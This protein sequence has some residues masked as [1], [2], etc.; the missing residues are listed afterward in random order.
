MQGKGYVKFFLI[1]LIIVSVAQYLFLLPTRKV[2]SAAESFATKAGMTATVDQK[3]AVMKVARAKYL[4]SMSSEKILSLPLMPSYTYDELKRQQLALGLDLKGGMSVLL[5]VDLAEF[6]KSLSGNSTDVNFTKALAAAQLQQNNSQ[7]DFVSLFVDEY[8]KTSNNAPLAPLFMRNQAFGSNVN[9]STSDATIKQLIRNKANET[10]DLTYKRLKE[11]IDKLGVVQPNISLDK[12]RDII[13]V[14]LPGIDNP[15]RARAFLSA[16]AKLEFWEVY[17]NSDPG[18]LSA[19]NEADARLK[20]MGTGAKFDSLTTIKDTSKTLAKKDSSKIGRGPLL[21]LMNLMPANESPIVAS[22]EKNKIEQINKYLATPEI[23]GLF[24]NDMEFRWS[25]KPFVD[26]AGK[27]SNTYQLYSL[28]KTRGKNGPALEGDR[29]TSAGVNPDPS[30]SQIMVSLGMDNEGTRTWGQL[31]TKCAAD[32]NREIAIVLDDEVE[33]SPRVTNPILTGNSQI[34]GTFTLQEGKDLANILQVGK[35]P[36]KTQIIQ[37]SL[38]GPSLGKENINASLMSLFAAFLAIV[39]FMIFYYSTGGVIAIISLILNIIFIIAALTSAGTVLTLPGIAGIVLTMG[40]AVDANVIIYERIRE[41]LTAG[42]N[43]MTAI[44]DGFNNSYSAII[45]GNLTTFIV[46]V[47]LWIFGLGPIKGFGIVLAIGIIFTLF[48]AVLVSHFL[49]DWWIGRGKEIKFFAPFTERAFKNI[50]IDWMKMRKKAYIFSSCIAIMGL[51]SYFSRGF[52]L[53]VD[54]KGGYSFNVEFDKSN[55]IESETFRK[56]LNT[57]FEGQSTIVKAVNTN[58]TYNVT[59]SYKITDNSPTAPDEVMSKLFSAANTIQGG[60][61]KLEDFKQADGK[62]THVSTF[63]KVGPTVADDIKSSSIWATIMGILSIALYILFRFNRWQYAVG[64][65]IALLHDVVFTLA[66]FSLLHGIL[67][68][69]M[70][71]DQ[72]FI[73][74]LLTII[75]Y[76]INDTVIVYDRIREYMKTYTKKPM[77]EVIN[78]AINS[79]LSRTVITVFTVIL[80]VLILFI[81]GGSSIR[82]FAFALLIGFL[83]GAYSSIFIASPVMMDLS[84]EIDLSEK[85]IDSKAIDKT[86]VKS[87]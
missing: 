43:M 67:P 79:T 34:S 32:R 65:I 29:V 10:V 7:S 81:F 40:M 75:G 25:S 16:T 55:K 13:V 69:S 61:L 17:R 30:T 44:K 49:I 59:T 20:A 76:S 48:T 31:T 58:N 72:A 77:N 66:F 51:V 38:V 73:A 56:A 62:G 74:A 9:I 37:E 47:I 42:K 12:A 19:F 24:P 22:A 41:E 57:A 83:T 8:K 3:E 68:F 78:D 4:D 80:V 52:E 23:R 87:K 27:A 46:A 5:K 15:Q 35:L 21:S 85:V 53:G 63:T 60:N 26:P 14:E 45:D 33:S 64:S 84:K 82:G 54:F 18:V 11:R 1:L 2:E 28:K 39:V 86:V 50:N 6:L 70:E 71:I 36:A